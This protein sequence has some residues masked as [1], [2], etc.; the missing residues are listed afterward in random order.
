MV[1]RSENLL[2]QPHSCQAHSVPLPQ[3]ACHHEPATVL[4]QLIH[5]SWKLLKFQTA[6]NTWWIHQSLL[7]KAQP[8]INCV[9]NN[10]WW[11]QGWIRSASRRLLTSGVSPSALTLA[12]ATAISVGVNGS[13]GCA[14]ECDLNPRLTPDPTAPPSPPTHFPLCSA[15]PTDQNLASR[16]MLDQMQIPRIYS[17]LQ[18]RIQLS[19]VAVD[20]ELYTILL[21]FSQEEIRV[22][23]EEFVVKMQVRERVFA[24]NFG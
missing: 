17:S 14:A 23:F 15:P 4:T 1:G 21:K 3:S 9:C 12:M 6:C 2:V 16:L 22:G 20:D 8:W 24:E 18:A 13:N 19:T 7:H 10:N 5:H 11:V